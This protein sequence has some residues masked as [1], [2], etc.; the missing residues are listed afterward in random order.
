MRDAK[1][2]RPCQSFCQVDLRHP[3]AIAVA[4]M[5]VVVVLLLHAAAWLAQCQ[6]LVTILQTADHITI[7]T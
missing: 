2:I 6:D 4:A 1:L 3:A 7:E 5:V